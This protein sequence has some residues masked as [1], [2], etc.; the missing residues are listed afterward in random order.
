MHSVNMDGKVLLAALMKKH[1]TNPHALAQQLKLPSLQ[2]QLQRFLDGKTKSPRWGT[3]APVAKALGAPVEAFFRPEIA[4]EVARAKG[5]L[6]PLPQGV[7]E[8]Q[9]DYSVAPA[10]I[11]IRA[12]AALSIGELVIALGAALAPHD[13]SARKAI[14][15][16]LED[17]TVHPENAQ[18]IGSRIA[19][20]LEAPGNDQPQRFIGSR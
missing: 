6:P 17:L 13:A 10:P 12:S 9:A 3:L 5:L 14:A 8:S 15:S 11:P 2:S 19:R 18:L 16:L 20:L 1:G 4:N 7:A